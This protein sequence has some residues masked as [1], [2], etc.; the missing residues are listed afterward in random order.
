ML[1]VCGPGIFPYLLKGIGKEISQNWFHSLPRQNIAIRFHIQ[2][3]VARATHFQ[4]ST[5][6]LQIDGVTG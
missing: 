4:M 5:F 2:P 6:E 1:L 3:A